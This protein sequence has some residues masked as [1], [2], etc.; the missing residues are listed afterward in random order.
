[1]HRFHNTTSPRI[2]ELI[3][4]KG[5]RPNAQFRQ[6]IEHDGELYPNVIG[7]TY[8][9]F[10]ILHPIMSDTHLGLIEVVSLPDDYQG[11]PAVPRGFKP[12]SMAKNAHN[13]CT[14]QH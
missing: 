9:T 2:G 6:L 5:R 7:M 13:R 8:T 11:K 4:P 1:M 14:C 3:V 12:P 10:P